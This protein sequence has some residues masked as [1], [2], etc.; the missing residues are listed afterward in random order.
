[1]IEYEASDAMEK[2]IQKLPVI[3]SINEVADF[4]QVEYM[5]VWHLIQRKELNAFKEGTD[6]CWCILRSDLKE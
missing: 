4:F 5:T 3:L 6:R 1:M 2:I